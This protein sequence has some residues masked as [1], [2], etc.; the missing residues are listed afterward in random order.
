VYKFVNLKTKTVIMSRNLI[1]LDKNY[2]EYKVI[3]AVNVELI[4]LVEVDN[5]EVEEIDPEIDKIEDNTVVPAPERNPAGRFSRELK[6]LMEFH[7]DPVPTWETA[8]VAML[9][10]AFCGEAF[11]SE[12]TLTS[13][14]DNGSNEPKTFK[15]KSKRKNQKEW[16]D[17]ICTEFKKM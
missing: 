13:G 7:L 15:E 5:E 14:F 6:C 17:A 8:E 16:W 12:K 2:A 11:Y 9:N 4:T 3:T 10:Q 1:W